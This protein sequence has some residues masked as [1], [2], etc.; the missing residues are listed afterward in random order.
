M[1]DDVHGPR[2]LV[3][4]R[5]HVAAVLLQEGEPVQR[6][7]LAPS[8]ELG[9]SADH[10]DGHARAPQPGDE[11]DPAQ[12]PD[13][14]GAASRLVA[15]NGVAHEPGPLV[16]PQRVGGDAG[17]GRDLSD[18]QVAPRQPGRVRVD[19]AHRVVHVHHDRDATPWS[20]L[21]LKPPPPGLPGS[22]LRSL[23]PHSLRRN[24][25]GRSFCPLRGAYNVPRIESAVD[26]AF[27][28]ATMATPVNC[29]RCDSTL[30]D[31]A[32]FCP[33]CGNHVSSGSPAGSGSPTQP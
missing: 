5:P 30:P 33:S 6:G 32:A 3:Q 31:D 25:G 27:V 24:F 26:A 15:G 29:P 28:P 12:V 18:R 17:D 1:I 13:P 22:P 11:D 9:V 2:Q 21:H 20:A 19:H 23:R 8:G 14:V 7:F 4:L 10:S 16:V